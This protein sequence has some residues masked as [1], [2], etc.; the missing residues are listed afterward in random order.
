MQPAEHHFIMRFHHS[1]YYYTRL[2]DLSP[3]PPTTARVTGLYFLKCL[4]T[5]NSL[6]FGVSS[7][8]PV[9][10]IFQNTSS[11]GLSNK[12]FPI[13]VARKLRNK[14]QCIFF[15][16]LPHF[17]LA[18]IPHVPTDKNALL[19]IGSLL[20]L[21]GKSLSHLISRKY[22]RS[23]S[24]FGCSNLGLKSQRQYVCK[25]GKLIYVCLSI[26]SMKQ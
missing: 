11:F 22:L 19:L 23:S 26:P 8:K 25:L 16:F 21:Q 6:S 7:L 3:T 10:L 18:F 15:P 12:D 9:H 13:E 17:N 24:G 1:G 14:N 20:F 4:L 2:R 5:V